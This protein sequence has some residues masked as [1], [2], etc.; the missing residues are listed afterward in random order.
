[1]PPWPPPACLASPSAAVCRSI[2]PVCR[3][4]AGVSCGLHAA[5]TPFVMHCLLWLRVAA[6]TAAHACPGG[7]ALP[8]A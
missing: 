4:A 5:C 2:G 8:A 6:G 7:A 1:M 3:T